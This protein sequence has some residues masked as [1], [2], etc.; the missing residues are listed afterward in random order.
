MF[1]QLE[2]QRVV[3]NRGSEHYGFESRREEFR[4]KS[5][6][7]QPSCNLAEGTNSLD[8]PLRTVLTEQILK[9][10]L[11]LIL[12]FLFT[13]GKVFLCTLPFGLFFK[14]FVVIKRAIADLADDI[15]MIYLDGVGGFC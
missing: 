15:V 9:K 2:E 6:H 12:L 8:S 5:C 13:P 4:F 11:C 7:G 10:H 14:W 3:F 1:L